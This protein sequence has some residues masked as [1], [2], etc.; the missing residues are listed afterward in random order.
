MGNDGDLGVE[1]A[2]NSNSELSN[3]DYLGIAQNVAIGEGGVSQP[4]DIMVIGTTDVPPASEVFVSHQY[5]RN[6]EVVAFHNTPRFFF[7]K[8]VSK[9]VSFEAEKRQEYWIGASI[10]SIIILV[11]FILW[12]ITLIV[13]KCLGPGRVGFLSG[14]RFEPAQVDETKNSTENKDYDHTTDNNLNKTKKSGPFSRV[15]QFFS[16]TKRK[17]VDP[18]HIRKVFVFSCV[19]LVTF[20]ILSVLMGLEGVPKAYYALEDLNLESRELLV[21][22][23]NLTTNLFTSGNSAMYIRDELL[24]NLDKYCKNDVSLPD[25][26]GIKK[27]VYMVP[28]QQV[29]TFMDV[30]LSGVTDL[31]IEIRDFFEV[32]DRYAWLTTR[33]RFLY[34]MIVLSLGIGSLIFIAGGILAYKR[35]SPIKFQRMQS[36]WVMPFFLVTLFFAC[37]VCCGLLLAVVINADF[38]SGETTGEQDLPQIIGPDATVLNIIRRKNVN[39][40]SMAY[41]IITSIVEGC[42]SDGPPVL[43]LGDEKQQLSNFT[44]SL[45]SIVKQFSGNFTSQLSAKCQKDVRPVRDG[46]VSVAGNMQVFQEDLG[47]VE[48]LLT[49]ENL[50]PLYTSVAHEVM[51]E[52]SIHALVWFYSSILVVTVCGMTII[53]LRSSWLQED[54]VVSVDTSLSLEDESNDDEETPIITKSDDSTIKAKN[55]G[56]AK[57]APTAL[58]KD[59]QEDLP[60]WLKD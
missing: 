42:R 31:I 16:H 37:I 55:P 33:L 19:S 44:N 48:Q 9:V 54:V 12:L 15:M 47:N 22:T 21:G 40:E 25:M 3:P 39:E 7:S 52:L 34:L 6:A 17:P 56:T 50:S 29:E 18:K 14:A 1:V 46:L 53:T 11:V 20:L 41:R 60:S 23:A 51:C 36:V 2:I 13:F 38:C 27:S 4:Q 59:Q 35:K 26:L 32:A 24:W 10:F 5:T 57:P 49:C 28:L 30:Y 8:D 58:L 43:D 45:K